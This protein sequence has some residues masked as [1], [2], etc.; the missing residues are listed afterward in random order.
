MSRV[1]LLADMNSF[2][3]SVHQALKPELRGKPVIVTG[4]PEK[5][6]GIVIAASYEAK[7]LGVKTGMLVGEAR[8][9]CPQGVFITSQY[10]HYVR[11]SSRILAIMRNFTPLVE[12]FSID[13][14]FLDVTGCEN[15]WGPPQEIARKLKQEIYQELKIKCSVGVGPNKLLAK[16]AAGLQKPD[17]LTVLTY[18]DVPK[19]LW[20]LPVRKL[21][22]V[23]RRYE[24]HLSRIGIWTIGGLAQCSVERLR[25]R[26]G[27]IGEVLRQCA[28]GI[29]PSP[30]DPHSL[31]E[32]KSM[33]HQITLPR[34]YVGE[35]V[36]VVLLELADMV[37]QRVRDK[38][39][40]GKTVT[41]VLRD[42]DLTWLSR[43]KT[44]SFYTDL[45][46]DLYQAAVELWKQHWS[47]V[48]P[49]RLVGLS[50]SNL[51]TGAA[52]QGTLFIDRDKIRKAEKTCD[53]LR[54]RYGE[55]A[56]FRAVSLMEAGVRYVP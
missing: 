4:D 5:R 22:G 36:K 53:I 12:P 9:L 54:Q 1:I 56:I 41:L 50:L 37:G 23:G 8:V 38:G 51:V 6:R 48:W 52:E 55:R 24:Q 39:Y 44:L 45:S 20:P 25:K 40:K 35:E 30:V 34:D 21:F 33:G 31:D 28:N 11:F 7:T 15:L 16:M 26:F 49:V 29:D 17:G 2:F 13:E 43:M 32:Y 14:A 3:A 42:A 47:P 19:R 46:L 10:H 27:V 18:A